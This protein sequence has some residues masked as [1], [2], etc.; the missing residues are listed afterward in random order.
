MVTPVCIVLVYDEQFTKHF[1]CT[2]LF[3]LSHKFMK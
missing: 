2:R 3:N 1:I